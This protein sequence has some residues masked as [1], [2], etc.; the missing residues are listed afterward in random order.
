[1]HIDSLYKNYIEYLSRLYHEP[2]PYGPDDRIIE[3]YS[4]ENIGPNTY[5][6]SICYTCNLSKIE[7]TNT[8]DVN[9]HGPNPILHLPSEALLNPEK[10]PALLPSFRIR[11]VWYSS[12][13]YDTINIT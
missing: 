6:K 5:G 4:D 9:L 10:Y 12:S 7:V 13:T 1:M 11:A 3:I 2:K 8:L